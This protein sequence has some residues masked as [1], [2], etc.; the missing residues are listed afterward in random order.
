MEEQV[1]RIRPHH[2][3]L[4]LRLVKVEEGRRE[5]YVRKELNDFSDPVEEDNALLDLKDFGRPLRYNG[6]FVKKFVELYKTLIETPD[7]NIQVVDGCD[8][9]CALD[10]GRRIQRCE[11]ESRESI[12]KLEGFGV[13]IGDVVPLSV[14]LEK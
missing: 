6:Q 4:L 7:A 3:S 8:Y 1:Y 14:L 13:R 9:V 2:I 10:C 5:D 11:R 12:E